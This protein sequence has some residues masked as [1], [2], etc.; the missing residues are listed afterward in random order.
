MRHFAWAI[1]L[2]LLVAPAVAGADDDA[3]PPA[4]QNEPTPA[5]TQDQSAVA[6]G[7][8]APTDDGPEALF[9]RL[10]AN[11]DGQ[12]GEDEVPEDQRRF[13][14]RLQRT[15]DRD[16]NGR[17]SREEF[18][19]G[20]AE[21]PLPPA[22]EPGQ[23]GQSPRPD[24]DPEQLFRFA[25]RNGDRKVTLDE[26]PEER[27]EAMRPRFVRADRDGD[28]AL[29][30]EEFGELARAFARN[31]RTQPG[32]PQPGQTDRR[33]AA[34]GERLFGAIDANGDGAL[35]AEEIAGAGEAIVKLDAN[36]DGA[37]TREE[38]RPQA[39]AAGDGPN[40]PQQAQA[41]IQRADRDG[42]GRVSKEEASG[43]L[44][45]H[46][47]RADANA[48]GFVDSGELTA[49]LPEIGPAAVGQDLRRRFAEADR[50]G[51]GK[52]SREEAPG[53]LG[54]S[55]DR[56]DANAD[57]S[58]D[59]PEV[60]Q[61]LNS[62]QSATGGLRRLIEQADRDGDGKVSRE[63]APERIRAGFD[64]LDAN[65]DGVLDEQE[66]RDRIQTPP[67]ENAPPPTLP[68]S[69]PEPAT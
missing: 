60:R 49:A 19:A 25:D 51:D 67:G 55:F 54:Q 32:Q 47:D 27:R 33:A 38:L 5:A 15:A 20:V 2:A 69:K 59:E 16:A 58:I 23:P 1:P 45:E 21:R 34:G 46:F 39:G 14:R 43:P 53:L 8:P 36:G 48:D 64:R 29:S 61:F 26:I 30:A 6:E 11:R 13:F 37:I 7:Q 12:I 44:Q 62:M 40:G 68:E 18:V 31:V 63:E 56:I 22:G 24:V 3:I 41:F 28:G 10:D 35:S 66:I 17:L 4:S 52:L 57:G 42:D 50:N 65:G 9:A